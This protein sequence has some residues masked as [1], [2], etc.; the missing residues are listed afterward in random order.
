H[1]KKKKMWKK[2]EKKVT[3]KSSTRDFE[4]LKKSDVSNEL[5]TDT[6]ET[7]LNNNEAV[8]GEPHGTKRTNET[9]ESS[10][11]ISTKK[12][13]QYEKEQGESSCAVATDTVDKSYEHPRT[14]L[15]DNLLLATQIENNNND[16]QRN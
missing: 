3:Q 4:D 16:A 9:T 10:E 2:N 15:L 1:C 7:S 6:K 8:I 13:R 11:S 5:Q 14:N 12:I